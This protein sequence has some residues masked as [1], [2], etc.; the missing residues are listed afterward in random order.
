MV[1]LV[2]FMGAGKTTIGHI[3]AERL[4]LP[5]VDSDVYIEQR[6]GR[7]IRDVFENEGER[8]FRQL[9]HETVAELVR[10]PDAVIALGGGAVLDPRTQ[11]ALQETRVVYLS[12]PYE[13]AVARI[14]GDRFR[15][16]LHRPDL[17]DIYA[18]RLPVYEAV[19]S[20]ITPTDGRRPEDVAL[21]VLTRLTVLPSV[22]SG[23]TSVLVS[24]VG[25]TYHA[26]LGPGLVSELRRLLPSLAAV[27]TVF[28]LEASADEA[29]ADRIAEQLDDLRVVRF[30]LDDAE[31]SKTFSTAA[32]VAAA[33][34]DAP[35]HRNDLVLGVGGEALG[36]LTGFVSAVFNRGT[37]FALVPTTLVAQA[38]S[39]VGGKNAV[40]L[41]SGRNL[42]GTFHQPVVV[43]SDTSIAARP[44]QRGFEPG[45]AEIAKH[46][47]ISDDG[48]YDRLLSR[49]PELRARDAAAV[50]D[51]TVRSVAV[52]AAIVSRDEREQGDRIHLNYGHTFAHAIEQLTG[53]DS[54]V[55]GGPLALGL[56]AAAHLAR[57]QG[58]I[59]DD[60]VDRHQSLLESL[61]L[62]TTARLDLDGLQRAWLRD[63]KYD[64]GVRFVVL[65]ALGAPVGGVAASE[66]ELRGALSDLEG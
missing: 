54:G 1:V 35:I 64:H 63:K 61:G 48:L 22:P 55:E 11:A 20:I 57:R 52:K 45:L 28:L 41:P 58:R 16:L 12:V 43:I 24:P 27:E 39:S 47:L 42:V 8:Y 9:E 40:N 59:G 53:T 21:D 60:V 30:V 14:Q 34:A 2:G 25:G 26:H 32:E 23:A 7:S 5:F 19:A 37:R 3:L 51:L 62:P 66:I 49:S 18:S 44:G 36:E 46:A 29:V 65:D 15:P 31:R 56:M 6:L 10:G 50:K 13:E 33:F 38:D 17:A 4:G